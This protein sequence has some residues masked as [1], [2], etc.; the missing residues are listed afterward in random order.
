MVK[1]QAAEVEHKFVQKNASNLRA[2]PVFGTNGLARFFLWDMD[3]ASVLASIRGI[4]LASLEIAWYF[5]A[6][7]P[8]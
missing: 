4:I 8:F 3:N 7:W 2:N 6:I 1:I 5:Q